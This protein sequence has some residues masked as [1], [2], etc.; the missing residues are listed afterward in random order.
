[1]S[2]AHFE[3]WE[4]WRAK[5]TPLSSVSPDPPKW[6]LPGLL[7]PGMVLL[8]GEAKTMK[9]TLALCLAAALG[10]KHPVPN[11]RYGKKLAVAKERRT[12]FYVAY[13]QSAGRL[14]VLYEKRILHRVLKKAETHVVMAKT[15]HY[16]QVDEP[17]MGCDIA[18]LIR[19]LKPILTVL[20]PLV[21]AH[22]QDE[23][24]PRM[25]RPF[26]PVREAALETGSCVMLVHH[27]N[28]GGG[29]EASGGR[30]GANRQSFNRVRG[31]SALWGMMDAGHLVSKS[32]SGGLY[33][34]SEFKDFP[35]RQWTWKKP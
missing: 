7:L 32:P 18:K 33:Y 34:T 35:A 27:M 4:K 15:P 9:T 17:Q 22:S 5:L 21:N 16:W 6:I 29:E 12:V 26:I 19:E 28:K 3:P 2:H 1:M 24:D 25:I 30:S 13:E 8:A 14:R 31:T 20:D 11:Y 23:N 10:D